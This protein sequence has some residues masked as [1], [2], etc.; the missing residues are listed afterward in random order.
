MNNILTFIVLTLLFV[1][2]TPQVITELPPK[3]DHLTVAIVHGVIF[4]IIVTFLMANNIVI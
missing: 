2:L 1:L 4:A 3:G